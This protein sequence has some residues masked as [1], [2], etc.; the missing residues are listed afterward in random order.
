MQSQSIRSSVISET[1]GR[2]SSSHI[3]LFQHF[4]SSTMSTPTTCAICAS[5]AKY[6]CPRCHTRTCSLPCSTAHKQTTNCTGIRDK[7]AYVPL[8]DYGYGKLM[9]D[10]V[11]LEEGKR[12]AEAWG[13]EIVGMKMVK[14]GP[15][16]GKTVAL[17]R[18]LRDAGVVVEF[19]PEGMEK[20]KKNQSHYNQK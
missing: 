11:F 20:R 14:E 8:K 18:A 10:Y 15:P 9:D 6:T 1:Q 4:L 17:Q 12:K 13:R 7:A 19:L 2:S 5:P 3:P 16:A